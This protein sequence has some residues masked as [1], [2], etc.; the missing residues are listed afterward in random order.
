MTPSMFLSRSDLIPSSRSP[1]MAASSFFLF[2]STAIVSSCLECYSLLCMPLSEARTGDER[3]RADV[4]PA[5][6]CI[7]LHH[8]HG[9]LQDVDGAPE[10]VV[11]GCRSKPRT[12]ASQ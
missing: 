9:N 2:S 12:E 11:D 3:A 7:P 1:W 5:G 6:C 4:T 10:Q 8:P